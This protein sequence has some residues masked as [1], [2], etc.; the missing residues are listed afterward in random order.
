MSAAD[1][2]NCSNCIFRSI[3]E[4]AP[5][6]WHCRYNPPSVTVLMVPAAPTLANPQGGIALQKRTDSPVVSARIVCA[7][8]PDWVSRAIMEQQEAKAQSKE[9]LLYQPTKPKEIQ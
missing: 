4:D 8:H 6:V 9:K 1:E 5:G 3:E 2:I 7:R